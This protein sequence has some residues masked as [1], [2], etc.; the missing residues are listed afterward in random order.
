MS[1]NCQKLGMARA[2]SGT[3]VPS[4]ALPKPKKT[5]KLARPVPVV[6]RPCPTFSLHIPIFF[7]LLPSFFNTNISHLSN[8]S[9]KT[10]ITTNLQT[11]IPPSNLHQIPQF[12]HH[13][14]SLHHP[15]H[16]SPIKT[17]FHPS[18]PKFTQNPIF[19]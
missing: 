16:N 19:H 8:L 11:F 17:N 13:N 9:L 6:A 12:L 1:P 3:G 4:H 14:N 7:L 5:S 18:P 15:K 2:C 10:S